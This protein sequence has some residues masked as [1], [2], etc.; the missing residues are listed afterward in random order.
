MAYNMG[1]WGDKFHS[2]FTNL[3]TA[4]VDISKFSIPATPDDNILELVRII[5]ILSMNE[6]VSIPINKIE[7][8]RILFTEGSRAYKKENVEDE[9]ILNLFETFSVF[10]LA[11][12][13]SSKDAIEQLANLYSY[14]DFRRVNVAKRIAGLQDDVKNNIGLAIILHYCLLVEYYFIMAFSLRNPTPAS[15]LIKALQMLDGWIEGTA[16][17]PVSL[18]LM[19]IELQMGCHVHASRTRELIKYVTDNCCRTVPVASL[20]L[21]LF[22]LQLRQ[23]LDRY[24][25]SGKDKQERY[26]LLTKF[27]EVLPKEDQII[28]DRAVLQ[29]IVVQFHQLIL[30]VH[31]EKSSAKK[32]YGASKPMT[33][34]TQ[35]LYVIYQHFFPSLPLPQLEQASTR[36][37]FAAVSVSGDSSTF[38][39][40]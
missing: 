28:T 4:P 9:R 24:H 22:K 6:R 40:Q 10:D 31:A 1:Y 18:G 27:F 35:D 15:N 8:I 14:N 37:D 20:D 25:H 21:G 38:S 3:P 23:I 16:L 34:T 39:Q 32:W 17:V 19:D 12:K 29:S 30:S 5:F 36:H 26:I 13:R 11:L 7:L 33:T 2:I